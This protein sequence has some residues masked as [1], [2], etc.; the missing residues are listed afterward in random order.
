MMESRFNTLSVIKLGVATDADPQSSVSTT[1]LVQAPTKAPVRVV[2]RN[3][4]FAAEVYL[5]FSEAALGTNE[6]GGGTYFLPAGVADVFMLAP[7]QQLHAISLSD[8]A[9]V[10]IGVSEALLEEKSR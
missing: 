6:P 1:L 4:S 10:S 7:T 3:I 2:V 9:R 8:N 5:A